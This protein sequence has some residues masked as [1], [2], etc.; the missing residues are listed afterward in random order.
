VL[1]TF[2]ISGIDQMIVVNNIA[3]VSKCEHHLADI[4]GYVDVAYIPNRG[5]IVGLSKLARVV[6][7]FTRR[8]QVQER[9]TDQL[10]DAFYKSPTLAPR[11]VGVVVRASHA[12]M[13]G[14]GV[15]AIGAMTT[16][17]ALRGVFLE[18]PEV[19]GEFLSLSHAT[20]PGR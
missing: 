11:G 1:R 18:K 10:A 13:S 19:R 9:L 20:L 7:I 2:E 4:T 16:T 3:F 6:D 8:L 12:C 5:R 15:R 14:R 17:S